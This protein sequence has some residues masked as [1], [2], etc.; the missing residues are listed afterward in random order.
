MN[1][2]YIISMEA[3]DLYDLKNNNYELPEVGDEKYYKL[4]KCVLD[5]SLD[6]IELEKYYKENFDEPFSFNDGF[7]N[8]CILSIVNV[9]FNIKIKID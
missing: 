6:Q 4:F 9:K 8:E 3:K 1:S 2:Y 7:D 5:Y